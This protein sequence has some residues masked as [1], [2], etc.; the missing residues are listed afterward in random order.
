MINK[1][2]ILVFFAT[3]VLLVAFSRKASAAYY[4]TGTLVS[5]NLLFDKSVGSINKFY[6]KAS[7]PVGTTTLK[8]QFKSTGGWVN[9]SN[10]PDGWNTL[11]D[12]GGGEAMIDLSGLVWSTANFYYRMEFGSTGGTATPILDAVRVDYSL[13]NN[14]PTCASLTA[15]PT[16]GNVPLAVNFTGT[17]SDSDGTIVEYAWDF[18]GNGTWDQTTASNATSYNYSSAGTY[19]AKLRVKDDDGVWSSTPASCQQTVSVS[20]PPAYQ[21]DKTMCDA[22]SGSG[23]GVVSALDIIKPDTTAARSQ[24]LWVVTGYSGV[25]FPSY[26]E[27]QTTYDYANATAITALSP[28]QIPSSGVYKITTG[29]TISSPPCTLPAAVVFVNGSL[30]ISS[31]FGGTV[32]GDP[33]TFKNNCNSSLAF[34]VKDD[35]TITQSVNNIYGI[36]YAGGNIIT[37]ALATPPDVKLYVFGSLLAGGFG[38][39]RNLGAD[40]AT[41]PAEQVIFMPKYFIT[42]KDVLGRS[43]VS[44]KEVK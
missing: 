33:L 13:P 18:D 26:S 5:K 4:S 24:R 39:G 34:I 22:S 20:T 31:N 8:V 7:V 10:T 19:P 11:S 44:W 41:Y 35:I 12:T 25:D 28:A 9:S 42:L 43:Q 37:E 3:L 40:N 32:S 15:N 17:G 6:Y 2:L 27:L 14:P 36:F 1:K 29:Y 23:G 38:L 30:T 21:P 16:S